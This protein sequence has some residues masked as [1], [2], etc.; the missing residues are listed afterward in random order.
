MI[1]V[2]AIIGRPNVGKSTLFNCLTKTRDAIVADV[3]GV[4]RDR[5]Y[6][7]G[8][9][10]EK[11]FV[12]IDTGGIEE[13]QGI[14]SLMT[15]HAKIAIQEA[16]VIL[17][18]V[19]GQSGL[20]VSDE[21]IAKE[22]RKVE[23]PVWLVINKTDG[24]NPD[25][26]KSDF[27]RLGFKEPI[28]I[29]ASHGRGITALIEIVLKNVE[30]SAQ[31]IQEPE[32]PGIKFALIGKPNV[33][34]STLANR[35]LG[36]ER[37]L[38]FDKPGTTR[39]S[40]FVPFERQGQKY[41]L[42]DTAG[43]RRRSRIEE[44]VEKFSVV[45]SMQAIEAADVIV[46][47][48]DA[49]ENIAE[50]DLRLIGHVLQAGR[51]LVIAINKWDGMAKDQKEAVKRELSRRLTFTDFARQHFISALH[52]TGVGDLFKS[53]NEAYR[54]VTCSL[55]TNTLTEILLAATEAHQPPLVNGRRIKLRYAH[56]GGRHPP[57]IVIHGTQT[58]A[59]PESYQRYLINTFR[60]KI[61]LMGAPI[62]LIFKTSKNPF[63]GR[64]NPGLG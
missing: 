34:K 39:D 23:K 58:K 10:G 18:L 54:S 59:V 45:K 52:G 56:Q 5:Q 63:E 35:I 36:E 53:I 46:F 32:E 13:E 55:K 43:I 1:P 37:V 11:P 4:T 17:F 12:V 24:M 33:G 62:V 7:Q 9:V 47:I 28:A 8:R 6:G 64:K 15:A 2:I 31:N 49:V 61:K 41:T 57:R 42:I 25:I 40:I 14:V 51:G 60:K 20:T 19:D 50:Q 26:A 21:T 22:L 38:V 48:I 16:D 44:A 30:S 29:A 27:Y 3:P